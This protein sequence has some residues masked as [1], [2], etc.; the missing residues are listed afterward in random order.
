MMINQ[1]RS[2]WVSLGVLLVPCLTWAEDIGSKTEMSRDEWLQ[3]VKTSVSVPVCKS[4]MQDESI[5]AQMKVKHI[6]Y[7]NCLSNVPPIATQCEKQFFADLPMVI[8]DQNAEKWGRLMGEC[9]GNT[10]AVQYLST[11]VP[12]SENGA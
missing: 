11:P 5:S 9:I 7:D 6:S 10:F 8:N 12:I 4:F 1:R 3:L 2:R